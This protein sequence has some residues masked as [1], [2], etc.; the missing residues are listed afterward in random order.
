[1]V[2]IASDLPEDAPAR[3]SAREYAV[4]T[5]AGLASGGG[6]ETELEWLGHHLQGIELALRAA[7]FTDHHPNPC[8]YVALIQSAQDRVSGLKKAAHEAGL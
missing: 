3:T 8:F 5:T 1:M 2:P 4:D 7:E 6:M